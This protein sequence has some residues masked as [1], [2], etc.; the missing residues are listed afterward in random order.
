MANSQDAANA[1]I[2]EAKAAWQRL[3]DKAAADSRPDRDPAVVVRRLVTTAAL[4]VAV[5]IVAGVIGSIAP[6]GMGGAMITI[7]ALILVGAGGLAWALKRPDAPDAKA[8]A[9]VQVDG[10][11]PSAIAWIGSRARALPAP[12][13]APLTSIADRLRTLEPMIAR[14]DPQ[15]PEAAEVRAL[16]AEQLPALVDDFERVPA[17]LRRT[18]RNGSTPETTLIHGLGVIEAET[19]EIMERLAQTDLDG[20][21]TR[22]RYLDMKYGDPA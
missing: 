5:L 1:A 15:G 8:I 2:A 13:Q 14:L 11:A 22:G 17:P 7:L 16:F 21:Q 18:E 20:L 3:Q 6:I 9:S 4:M 19:A 12:A 10:I